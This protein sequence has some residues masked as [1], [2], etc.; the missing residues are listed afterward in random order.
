MGDSRHSRDGQLWTEIK[1]C[2]QTFQLVYWAIAAS[3]LK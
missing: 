1:H 3:G 2:I